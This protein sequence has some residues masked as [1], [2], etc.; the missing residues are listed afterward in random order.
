M[1][2]ISLKD[3]FL[4]VSNQRLGTLIAFA[5]QVGGE[6]AHSDAE[7]GWVNK[8]RT[9]ENEA[10]PGI[11]FE[12]DE[13]IFIRQLGN[14]EVTFWQSSAI[15][16][17][18]VTARMLTRAVQEIELAPR[19]REH[20]RGRCPLQWPYQHPG[21]GAT[22]NESLHASRSPVSVPTRATRCSPRPFP[23]LWGLFSRKRLTPPRIRCPI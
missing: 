17:A 3:Q 19:N 13:R 21:V 8:L 4:W 16:D 7:R 23:V 15:G 20:P 22:P 11:V 12:L 5:L 9:F 2:D 10:W 1:S 18:Y 14:H 6:L